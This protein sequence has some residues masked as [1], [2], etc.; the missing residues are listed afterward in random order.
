M[1]YKKELTRYIPINALKTTL[2]E[3][4][5]T[6]DFAIGIICFS[7]FAMLQRKGENH[8]YPIKSRQ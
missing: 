2:K 6:L 1:K 8:V 4:A 3:V 7:I 5:E